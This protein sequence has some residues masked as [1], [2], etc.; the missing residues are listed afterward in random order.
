MH[1][2]TSSTGVDVEKV[3]ISAGDLSVSILTWGA[4]IQDVRLAG[5]DHS[6]TL[7][8]DDLADYEG[9]LRHHG[10]LIGPIANR[11]SNAR[12]KIDG[13]MYELERNQDGAIHLHSG[14]QA[15]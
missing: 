7:G 1:F 8:S 13:M 5:V 14:A 4:I 15:T 12:V 6:L 9:G 10:S 11:I 3:T 2:G